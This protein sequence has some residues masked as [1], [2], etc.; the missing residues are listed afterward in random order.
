M[1]GLITSDLLRGLAT[2]LAPE[3][4]ALFASVLDEALEKADVYTNR[5]IRHFLAQVME[6][7]G[8]LRGLVESTNYR[9]PER[10]DQLFLNVQGVDHA[11]RLIAAGPEAI[12]NTIY[13]NKNG[14]GGVGSG[15]G[16]RYRGRGFL[17]ITGRANY[18]RIGALVGMPLEDDPDLLGQ[19][20]PAAQAAAAYWKARA[21]NVPADADDVSA[22]TFLVNGPAR[23]HLAE[24]TAWL[25]KA[26]AIWADAVAAP[27]AP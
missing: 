20:V 18:R 27:A 9:D 16:F 3:R 23:L 25:S 13:A 24:R 5:R 2:T 10:L 26:K 12:G 22:V 14:N 6:E 11:R 19:P 17:Q 1:P 15:D 21:I 8:A 7:T 4:V